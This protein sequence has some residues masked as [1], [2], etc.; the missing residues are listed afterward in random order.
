MRI[1]SNKNRLPRYAVFSEPPIS[2][3][4]FESN[5]GTTALQWAIDHADE[6]IDVYPTIEI[7]RSIHEKRTGNTRIITRGE[8]E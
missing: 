6:P 7:T 3:L 4:L 5:D 2:K 8:S 1:T